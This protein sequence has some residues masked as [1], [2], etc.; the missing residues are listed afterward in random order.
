MFLEYV[1]Y[2]WRAGGEGRGGDS[3]LCYVYITGTALPQW[4]RKMDGGSRETYGDDCAARERPDCVLAQ[5]LVLPRLT[6]RR[7]SAG[8]LLQSCRRV[9]RVGRCTGRENGS[10]RDDGVQPAAAGFLIYPIL[11]VGTTSGVHLFVIQ[12]SNLGVRE[13]IP[14]AVAVGVIVG[15]R[16]VEVFVHLRPRG[17][18]T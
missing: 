18:G 1:V 15:R 13:P 6:Q 12:R 3:Q 11:D 17:T 2:V 9:G 7:R 8:L 14:V 5:L 4:E 10:G 16:A